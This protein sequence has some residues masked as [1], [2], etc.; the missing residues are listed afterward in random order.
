M[1]MFDD[2]DS[3]R[4]GL[5][6]TLGGE[7]KL[8]ELRY[9][10]AGATSRRETVAIVYGWEKEHW[11]DLRARLTGALARGPMVDVVGAVCTQERLDDA[12]AFFSPKVDEMPGAKRPLD[13]AVE[14]AGLCIALRE[15]GEA[16][17]ASWLSG[18]REAAVASPAAAAR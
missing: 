7:L 6:L 17:A 14:T 9:V 18:H 12:R 16:L 15:H 2:A 3:L 1:G 5:D 8:S 11:S 10:F 4:Q 13:E